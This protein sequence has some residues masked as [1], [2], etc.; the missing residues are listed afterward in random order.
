MADAKR[1]DAWQHTSTLLALLANIHR[2]PKKKPQP[3]SPAEF[4]PLNNERKRPAKV[5]AGIR[6]LKSLFVDRR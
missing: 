6:I 1:H 5:K 3:F 4:N 2:N